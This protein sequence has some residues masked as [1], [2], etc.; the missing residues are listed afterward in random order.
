M[1]INSSKEKNLLFEVQLSG[2]SPNDLFGHFRIVIDGIEYGFPAKISESAISVD[3]PRLKNIITRP[4]REG[5]TFKAKLELVGNENHIPCW[6]GDVTIKSS[7]MVEAKL[8]DK[9]ITKKPMVKLVE[10]KKSEPIK[11]KKVI[12]EYKPVVKK[13]NIKITKEHLRKYMEQHG[14]KNKLIQ[15]VMLEQI[16][17]KVGDDPKKI[18]ESLYKYYRKEEN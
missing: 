6:N 7:V 4:L 3:I 16:I 10:H 14:T 11:Q 12:Q 9:E 5:E 8:V 2:I 15:N 1:E 18:F 17:Q 13:K